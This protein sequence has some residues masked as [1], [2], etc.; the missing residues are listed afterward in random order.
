MAGLGLCHQMVMASLPRGF[1]PRG[2]PIGSHKAQSKP[3]ASV[4]ATGAQHRHE[5]PHEEANP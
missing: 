1:E 4:V 3:H 2:K 5:N